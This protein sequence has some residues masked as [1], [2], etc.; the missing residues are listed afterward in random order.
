M[1]IFECCEDIFKKYP[2]VSAEEKIEILRVVQEENFDIIEER[3][4]NFEWR[5]MILHLYGVK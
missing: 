3:G 1:L 5:K 2:L 4:E